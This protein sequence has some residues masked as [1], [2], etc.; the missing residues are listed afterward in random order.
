MTAKKMKI[1]N[2]NQ[3][4]TLIE[5]LITFAL[6]GF[7]LASLYTFY[8]TGLRSWQRGTA[9]MEAQQSARIAVDMMISELR[10]AHELKLHSNNHEVRFKISPDVRT[11]RFRL[12]GEEL[13][14]ESYPT[15]TFNY[16]HNKV[17]IGIKELEFALSEDQLLQVTLTAEVDSCRVTL[18]DSIRP[19]NLP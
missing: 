17:A 5:L 4:F 6:V 7:V 13:V 3:G 2:N 15:G 11:R 18:I 9:V 8:L 10:Y 1:I 14:Y 12:V 19:R 16:F